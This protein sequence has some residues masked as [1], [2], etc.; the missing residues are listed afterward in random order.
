MSNPLDPHRSRR[1]GFLTNRHAKKSEDQHRFLDTPRGPQ[2]AGYVPG[3]GV[4]GE[5]AVYFADDPRKLYQ[6]K[7]WLPVFE[8]LDSRH[9]LVIITRHPKTYAE[10]GE[11]SG[12]RRVLAPAFP[13]LANLYETSGFKVAVYVNNSVHNFHSLRQSRMLH[14]HVNHGESDKVCMV[15]NQVKAYDR[16]FV[17]GEAAIARHAAA[18]LEFDLG[19]LVPVGRPQ[20]DL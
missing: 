19:A 10:L 2:P 12:L 16:V 13:D 15:S 5:I 7:Q 3:E 20:L 14:V 18:L 1:V 4:P 17:A 6:L 8:R 11:V 9:R